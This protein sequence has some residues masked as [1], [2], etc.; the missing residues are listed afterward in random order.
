MEENR[1]MLELL[2]KIHKT[3]RLQAIISSILC[4][5]ALAAAVCCIVIF[6]SVYEMLPQLNEIIGQMEV[7]LGNL[8]QTTQQLAALD[9]QSMVQDVD[10]LV[11]TGQQ[12]LEQTMAKL[13]TIDLETLN[14][15]IKDLAAVIEPLARFF[16]AFS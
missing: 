5:F 3:N 1:E 2:T 4:V 14:R 12:S 11:A 16:N 6:A 15:A 13:D 10:A 9:L 8:E 7:V